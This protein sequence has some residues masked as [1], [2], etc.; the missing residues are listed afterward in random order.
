MTTRASGAKTSIKFAQERE[1][2]QPFT[3]EQPMGNVYSIN[4]RSVGLGGSK[5]Q[6]Q[7]ETI[8]DK[9]AVLGLGE[10]N[11]AVEGDIVTDFQPEGQ[12]IFWRHL[13]G[14]EAGEDT[15]KTGLV[16]TT[17]SAP[18]TTDIDHE[19]NGYSK[20][21]MKGAADTHQGLVIQKAFTSI[22]EFYVYAGCRV[23]T[24][25]LNIIQ[26]GFHDINWN[27]IGTSEDIQDTDFFA[28]KVPS[29]VTDSG[30]TGYQATL[31]VK[32]GAHKFMGDDVA[33]DTDWVKL[34]FVTQ[35]N[36]TI[37][38]DIETDGYVIGSDVRESAEHGVRNCS[39][40]WT[41]FYHNS[42]IYQLYQQGVESAI[43]FVF[44]NHDPDPN[45][46]KVIRIT[47]PAVKFGGES[48]PIESAQG[49][50]LDL[51]FQAKYDQT[52]GT[53]VIVEFINK[54][55]TALEGEKYEAPAS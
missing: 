12:E 43:R 2:K 28:G 45:K 8:N 48:A 42:E 11:K 55:S 23:N 29:E 33:A 25:T 17:I 18:E 26:E 3:E 19:F 20:L 24:M 21:T 40:S 47:F 30:F 44:D 38:N 9:R 34:G 16:R 36:I 49:G 51:T 15:D 46:R 31:E 1:W 4:Y 41:M 37:T 54:T 6:F 52:S 35:G 14:K 53:D 50:N 5:N 22:E 10:G 13:L 32:K 39:G 7:S 27:I